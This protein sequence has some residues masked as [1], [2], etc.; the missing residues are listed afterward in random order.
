M[1][2][3]NCQKI[4]FKIL[5]QIANIE[6]HSLFKALAVYRDLPSHILT[7]SQV[8]IKIL[9]Q[10]FGGGVY[11]LYKSIN[12]HAMYQ[13]TPCWNDISLRYKITIIH[14]HKQYAVATKTVSHYSTLATTVCLPLEMQL[15]TVDKIF[16]CLRIC[17]MAC[18]PLNTDPLWSRETSEHWSA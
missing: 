10:S 4:V 16:F 17:E 12:V 7:P 1:V 11:K 5:K 2:I 3:S 18:T 13:V 8:I 14:K 6:H 9:H 15:L